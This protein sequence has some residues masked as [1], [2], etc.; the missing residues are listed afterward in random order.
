MQ[1]RQCGLGYPGRYAT[2]AQVIG[3][4]EVAVQH[5]ASTWRSALLCCGAQPKERAGGGLLRDTASMLKDEIQRESVHVVARS[6]GYTAEM[7]VQA[8]RECQGKRCPVLSGC[9]EVCQIVE[10]NGKHTRVAVEEEKGNN[11]QSSALRSEEGEDQERL[12]GSDAV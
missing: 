4:A 7:R 2:P 8:S 6:E 12:L 11:A 9:D 10:E 5:R 3:G 1:N